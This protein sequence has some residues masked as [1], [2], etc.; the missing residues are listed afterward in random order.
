MTPAESALATARRLMEAWEKTRGPWYQRNAHVSRHPDGKGVGGTMHT[1]H[2]A[3]AV[4][5]EDAAFIAA[6]H[7][8]LPALCRA[9][10][11][12]EAEVARLRAWR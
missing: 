10:D 12:A 6:A 8:Q 2:V 4:S 1:H 9:L 5:A 7:T 11:E 3:S